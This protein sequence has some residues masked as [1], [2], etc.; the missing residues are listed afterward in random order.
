MARITVARASP[1]AFV[2]PQPCAC[3]GNR[4]RPDREGLTEVKEKLGHGPF[5][6]WIEREFAWARTTAERFM[7]VYERVKLPNLGNLDID[8][9]ALYLIAQPKTPEPARNDIIRRASNGGIRHPPGDAGP[10]AALHAGSRAIQ[11]MQFDQS[12]H[13]R[14]RRTAVKTDSTSSV[15]GPAP[16]RVG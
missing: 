2:N 14:R 6:D 5:I 1:L 11:I 13:R 7:N 10:C 16:T 3:D 15:L 9:S 12:R 8:V 4:H